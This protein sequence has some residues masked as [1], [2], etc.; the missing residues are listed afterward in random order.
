MFFV[1]GHLS[2]K[3]LVFIEG[4]ENHLKQLISSAKGDEDVLI[5]DRKEQEKETIKIV[6]K[7]ITDEKLL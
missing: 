4:M 1:A 6:L 5:S 7:E 3:M 2:I